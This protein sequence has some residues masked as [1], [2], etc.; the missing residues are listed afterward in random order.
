MS[1]VSVALPDDGYVQDQFLVATDA[2]AAGAI[3]RGDL[4]RGYTKVYRNVY[5]RTG[6][7]LTA[8]DRARAA[9]LW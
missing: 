7:K 8:A 3:V 1:D 5:V 9:W 6:T 4:E 2:I